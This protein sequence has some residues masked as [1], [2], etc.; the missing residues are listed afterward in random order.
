MRRSCRRRGRRVLRSG[1][2]CRP[3]TPQGALES[4]WVSA[5]DASRKARVKLSAYDTAARECVRA[6]ASGSA[7]M[8]GFY[9]V[10]A[11]VR[12]TALTTQL[13]TVTHTAPGTPD[14]AIQALSSGGYG[15]ATQDEGHTLLSVVANLQTRVSE[16]ETKL[17]SLG[18]LT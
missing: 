10:A 9:G 5:T 13:T 2:C 7:A 12:P 16:L 4:A 1:S 18:L 6:E 3:P 8:L 14:Y 17:R 15:F 11:V